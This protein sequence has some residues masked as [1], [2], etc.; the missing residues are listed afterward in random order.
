MIEVR[1]ITRRAPIC[2]RSVIN[3]SVIPSAKYSWDASP[4]RFSKGSTANERMTGEG[5]GRMMRRNES[6]QIHPA[7]AATTVIAAK[8]SHHRRLGLNGDLESSAGFWA[9]AGSTAAS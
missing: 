7:K 6:R 9:T 1:E 8:E 4:V 5:L 3:A 2:A